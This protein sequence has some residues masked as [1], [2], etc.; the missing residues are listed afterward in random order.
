M[1]IEKAGVLE[2]FNKSEN[3]GKIV[4]VLFGITCMMG[5]VIWNI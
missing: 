2:F 4:L 3:I 1:L 5:W